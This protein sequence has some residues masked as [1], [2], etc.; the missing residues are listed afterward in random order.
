MNHLT[1]SAAPMLCSQIRSN[2]TITQQKQ[3]YL[4]Y[5]SIYS[6]I[7]IISNSNSTKH[8]SIHYPYRSRVPVVLE[9]RQTIRYSHFESLINLTCM[10][11]DCGGKPEAYLAYL[12]IHNLHMHLFA[13]TVLWLYYV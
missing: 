11:L 6:L 8:P 5:C 3:K 9:Q 12:L 7:F 2:Q 13:F 1:H 10:F 4:V